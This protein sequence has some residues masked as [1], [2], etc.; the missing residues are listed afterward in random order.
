V[1]LID[2]EGKKIVLGV[3]GS[4]AAYKACELAR[5]FVRSGADVHVVMSEAAERFVSPLTF[6]ALTG[7][8]VLSS[9]SESWSRGLNHIEISR[10]ADLFVIAPATANTI[11]KLSKGI[12]DTILLQSALA[13]KGALVIA[14]AA[15]SRMLQNHYTEGSLKMLLV[16][17]CTIVSPQNKRLACNEEGNGALAQVQEIYWQSC[18]EIYK[19]S[20]WED[21]KVVVTGGGTREAIDSFRYVSNRS[22]GKMARELATALYL[23]GADVCFVT[24]ALFDDMPQDIYTIVVESAEEMLEYTVDAVRVAKKGKLSRASMNRSEPVSLV[25]KRPYLFMAAAVSDYRPLYAQEGKLKKSELGERWSLEMTEN[26]DI[27]KSV[28]KNNLVTVA[29]KAESDADKGPQNA[30]SLLKDKEVDAVCYNHIADSSAFGGD[31]N[32]VLFI[33]ENGEKL[34]PRAD[35]FTIAAQIVEASEALCDES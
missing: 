16:N 3:S 14:P 10:G 19:K 28:D 23:R 32:E 30:R 35:K 2:L 6:E 21:R 22:S 7:K 20:F 1:K 13:W 9:S 12:A 34:L 26:P 5:A 33:Y 18:R 24:T 8:E 27:L 17:D 29:F 11:N 31:E 15:N 25:R 4:I